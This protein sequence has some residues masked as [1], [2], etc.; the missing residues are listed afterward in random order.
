MRLQTLI[1]NASLSD[2]RVKYH[3]R[4]PPRGKIYFFN[5]GN[6]MSFQP[7]VT[8]YLKSTK[9]PSPPKSP[10]SPG[11]I[12]SMPV[13]DVHRTFSTEG[14][15]VTRTIRRARIGNCNCY[16]R[17]SPWLIWQNGFVFAIPSQPLTTPPTHISY[18]LARRRGGLRRQEQNGFLTLYRLVFMSDALCF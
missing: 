11:Y 17:R 8:A 1:S 16:T 4:I 10:Y 9:L 12:G 5:E 15:L 2:F 7:P 18:L 6:T 3:S 14:F 13:A